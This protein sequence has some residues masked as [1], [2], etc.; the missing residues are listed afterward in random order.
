M[1]AHALPARTASA[2]RAWARDNLLLLA[3][4]PALA[5]FA[6]IFVYPNLRFIASGL[7]TGLDQ[8]PGVADI[9]TGRSMLGR[10]MFMSIALGLCTTIATLL[11]GYPIA[12]YLARS[13]S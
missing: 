4:A 3:L 2:P 1:R 9:L 6:V 11:V 13:T 10:L 7:I 12:Y 5:L 8:A